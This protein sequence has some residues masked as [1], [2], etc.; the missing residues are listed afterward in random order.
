M[1]KISFDTLIVTTPND[2][3]RLSTHYDRIIANINCNNFIIISSDDIIPYLK[4]FNLLDK[5]IFINENDILP[6]EHV[7]EVMADC[8]K[9][10]LQGEPVPRK[11]TGWYYQQFLKMSYASISQTDYYMTWDGDTIPCRP[12]SMFKNDTNIPYM[13]IKNEYH[14]AY[15]KTLEKILP[16]M[17]KAIA[18]SFISEHMLFSKKIMQ[19][20]ISKI[21]SNNTIPGGTYWEKILHSMTPTD[22]ANASFSE[23]ETYGTFVCFTNPSIYMLRDWHSFR[24]GA[25][26]FDPNT[27]CERDFNWLGKDFF[28]ISFE[29]NQTVKDGNGN[30]FDNPIYQQK[31]SAKKM[32]EIAQK[33]FKGGYIEQWG[34]P[35]NINHIDPLD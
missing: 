22:I 16:G 30:L 4:E 33:E 26:F 24:L 1:N 14:S 5:V 28:A 31:L 19:S 35:N 2:F 18:A 17:H 11:A 25:E 3:K 34:D 15:F 21:E 13:D 10:I 8:L 12:I 7:N 27:I 20:L 29:K 23:F 9:D 6:F 32:L